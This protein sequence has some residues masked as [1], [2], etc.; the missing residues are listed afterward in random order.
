MQQNGFEV[1]TEIYEDQAE[2]KELYDVPLELSSC[3]TAL[4]DGY[5]IEGHV[6]ADEVKRL[7]SQK[8]NAVG[9]AVPDMPLES[10]GMELGETPERYDVLLLGKNGEAHIYATYIGKKKI[11]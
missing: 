4:I 11:K 6:P 3:H 7:L 9:I 8:P 10:P 5:V 2:L 1:R